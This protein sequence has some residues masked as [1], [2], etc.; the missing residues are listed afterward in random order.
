MV[1]RV[2]QNWYEGR[3]SGTSR[4]GIFPANYVQVLKEPRVKNA[5]E[6]P[7]SPS[8]RAAHSGSPSQL[9][10][11]SLGSRWQSDTSPSTLRGSLTTDVLSSSSSHSGFTFPVSPKLEHSEAVPHRPQSTPR[12]ALF[13]PHSQSPA[14]AS[15]SPQPA[16][17]FQKQEMPRPAVSASASQ[18]G[19]L[20]PLQVRVLAR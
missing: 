4:Q 3:I 5:E 17:T 7:P 6:F 8:L 14:T 1:R 15:S 13:S 18:P 11:P 2:D 19:V 20:F 16:S 12:P 9:H 10:S